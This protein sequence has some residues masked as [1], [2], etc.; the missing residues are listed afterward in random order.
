[1]SPKN[2]SEVSHSDAKVIFIFACFPSGTQEVFPSFRSTCRHHANVLY[3]FHQD[4]VVIHCIWKVTTVLCYCLVLFQVT[5]VNNQFN[6]RHLVMTKGY[7]LK[8]IFSKHLDSVPKLCLFL[9]I[10]TQQHIIMKPV[11]F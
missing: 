1:M 10:T 2:Q 7:R 11:S 8:Y 5:V 3:F 6:T 9:R 4:P